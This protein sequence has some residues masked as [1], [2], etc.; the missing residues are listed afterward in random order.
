M[1]KFLNQNWTGNQKAFRFEIPGVGGDF[2][3]EGGGGVLGS[4]NMRGLIAAAGLG[5]ASYFGLPSWL[6]G[7]GGEAAAGAAGTS[8]ASSWASY[9]PW[10][11]MGLQA[12]GASNANAAN[13]GIAQDQMAFQA[14]MSSTA[15][16]REVADLKAAGLNPILSANAGASSPAG[17]GATM[18]NPFEGAAANAIEGAMMKGA[19]AKQSGEIQNLHAQNDLI[20]SQKQKTDK[21]TR[22][23]SRDAERGDFFGRLWK[24]ANE[25]VDFGANSV[26]DWDSKKANAQKIYDKLHT[27]GKK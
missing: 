11:G 13:R 2:T 26:S 14:A 7:S 9:A 12:M 1:V 22:A 18:S 25:A 6:A 23:L 15:H 5:A 3:D 17:A 19:L 16:Q 20:R 8:G 10:V 4:G 21:E 27:G 24:K